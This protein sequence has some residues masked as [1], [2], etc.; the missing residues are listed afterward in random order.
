[1]HER[2]KEIVA[3]SQLNQNQFSKM[4]GV[5]VGATNKALN[6]NEFGAKVIL[7]VLNAYPEV[8]AEWFMRGEGTMLRPLASIGG[9]L[10]AGSNAMY[11]HLQELRSLL[12]IVSRELDT[13]ASALKTSE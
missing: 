12:R 8:S 2:L 9:D 5:S 7:G 4:I 13:F 6:K 11:T 10:P 1:M 3:Y